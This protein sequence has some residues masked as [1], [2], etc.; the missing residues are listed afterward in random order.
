MGEVEKLL[1]EGQPYFPEDTLTDQPEKVIAQE[2]I[3]E[4]ILQLL[5]D[6]VPHGTGVEV[7][8]YKEN[9]NNGVLEI[10]ANIYCERDPTRASSSARAA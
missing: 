1:P 2:M 6:E 8:Q 4:K 5:S 3:R 9:G 10:D 7:L